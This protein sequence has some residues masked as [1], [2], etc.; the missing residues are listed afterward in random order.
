MIYFLQDEMDGKSRTQLEKRSRRKR[1]D[2]RR[3]RNVIEVLEIS[4]LHLIVSLVTT[5]SFH[6]TKGD[7]EKKNVSQRVSSLMCHK[8]YLH[9][10]KKVFDL[11]GRSM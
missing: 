8:K 4:S 7:L 2:P 10:R 11:E 9:S 3:P 5:V 6:L 1:C